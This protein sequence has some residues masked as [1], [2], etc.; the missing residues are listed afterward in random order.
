MQD[1]L[2]LEVLNILI[3]IAGIFGLICCLYKV[4]TSYKDEN[5]SAVFA[6]I[7]SSLLWQKLI[8]ES[9]M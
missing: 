2:K 5:K 3:L 4:W 6:W 8:V 9:L 7:I 1:E